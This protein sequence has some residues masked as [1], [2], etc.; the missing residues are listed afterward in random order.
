MDDDM[1][2]RHDPLSPEEDTMTEKTAGKIEITAVVDDGRGIGTIWK[3]RTFRSGRFEWIESVGQ[4]FGVHTQA[5]AI[6]AA[7][8]EGII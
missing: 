7:K 3:I 6:A 8:A 2:V 4:V 5:E 1:G